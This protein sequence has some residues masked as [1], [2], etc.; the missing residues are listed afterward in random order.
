MLCRVCST[1]SSAAAAAHAQYKRNMRTS[2]AYNVGLLNTLY[3]VV[4]K[5]LCCSEAVF[6]PFTRTG[7]F[8]QSRALVTV[9]HSLHM[10]T[11]KA[12][13]QF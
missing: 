9:M 3:G 6:R 12:V 5:M 2:T 4:F 11:H 1:L 13:T 7:S 8:N 10:Q